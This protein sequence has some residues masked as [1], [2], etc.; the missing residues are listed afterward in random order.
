MDSLRTSPV[1]LLAVLVILGLC[2]IIGVAYVQPDL[3]GELVSGTP[4]WLTI[5][6]IIALFPILHIALAPIFHA[7]VLLLVSLV[8]TILGIYKRRGMTPYR[9]RQQH[10]QSRSDR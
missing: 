1:R 4:G 3:I 7:A 10:D 5:S 6:G 8:I 9:G 2:G